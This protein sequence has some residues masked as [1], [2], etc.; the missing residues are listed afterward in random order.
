MSANARCQAFLTN[1]TVC[2]SPC[3]T[4]A[5]DF[6]CNMLIQISVTL[7]SWKMVPST[8][9]T[10]RFCMTAWGFYNYGCT[11]YRKTPLLTIPECFIDIK[12]HPFSGHLLT[13]GGRKPIIN[14]AASNI[15]L[16]SV[17][18]E[19]WILISICRWRKSHCEKENGEM[20]NMIAWNRPLFR[21]QVNFM[22]ALRY[23]IS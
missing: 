7:H 2:C 9:S 3:Q 8:W 23:Y 12:P 14:I 15:E 10:M 17:Q 11:K 19:S 18:S 1:R 4:N 22:R 20:R 6:I 13:T 16:S 21:S 5:L